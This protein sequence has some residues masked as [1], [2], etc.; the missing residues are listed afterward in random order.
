[1][2]VSVESFQ[3]SWVCFFFPLPVMYFFVV[4]VFFFFQLWL[5]SSF[6]L[7]G[8]SLSFLKRSGTGSTEGLQR[9]RS[10]SLRREAAGGGT[11]CSQAQA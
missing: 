7:D 4:G 10:W 6:S 2:H 1:M 11:N 8:F 9:C 5:L 3:S